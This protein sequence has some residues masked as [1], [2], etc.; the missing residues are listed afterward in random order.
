MVKECD[1]V[2]LTVPLTPQTRHI[3]NED[4]IDTM[5]ETAVLINVSRGG[6]VDE[7]ALISALAAK[8]IRGA[9]L[10]VFQEEP[11]PTTSPL[12]NLENVIISP[13]ISGNAASY[14]HKAADLFAENLQRYLDGE[15]L[16]N[17]LQEMLVIKKL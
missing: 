10:D 1:Y 6:V 14:H 13:H 12:W 9:A 3:V 4:I 7:E 5:Q 8:K 17:R 16:L 11:L 2:V 15:P